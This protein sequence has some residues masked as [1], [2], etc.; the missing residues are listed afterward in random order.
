MLSLSLTHSHTLTVHRLLVIFTDNNSLIVN[1]IDIRRIL[2]TVQKHITRRFM[3][4]F[5]VLAKTKM[6]VIAIYV[7]CASTGPALKLQHLLYPP[8]P[9][10]HIFRYISI[11]LLIVSNFLTFTEVIHLEFR[12][13]AR[14]VWCDINQS[15]YA[16]L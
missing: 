3:R 7:C 10:S 5:F 14:I 15:L 16:H 11:Q 8:Y 12:I 1:D 9:C 2:L 4:S 13:H 6:L